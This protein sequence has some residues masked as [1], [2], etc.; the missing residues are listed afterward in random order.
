MKKSSAEGGCRRCPHI[1]RARHRGNLTRYVPGLRGGLNLVGADN[2]VIAVELV[3]S[4]RLG[5]GQ[6]RLWLRVTHVLRHLEYSCHYG[7]PTLR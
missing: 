6:F 5:Q 7:L 2:P 1:V 4:P 3:F